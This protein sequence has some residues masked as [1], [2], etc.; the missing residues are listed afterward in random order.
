MK[1]LGKLLG[2]LIVLGIIVVGAGFF[3]LPK[4]AT[5]QEVIAVDKPAETV[6]ALLASTP[7]AGESIGEGATQTLKTA[8]PPDTVVFDV[9]YADGVKGVAT[10]KVAA[11]G[12]KASKVTVT[13]DKPLGDDINARLGALT[14][15][16][17]TP[18]M[19]SAKK[20]FLADAAKLNGEP[21]TDLVYEI[22][23][24]QPAPF[25]FTVGSAP[26]DAAQIKEAVGQGLGIVD[27]MIKRTGARID[28]APIAVETAWKDNKY[29]FTAGWK[30]LGNPP[31]IYAGGVQVGTSPGGQAIKVTYTG[32][33]D[34]VLPTYDKM[35]ALVGAARLNLGKSFEVYRDDPT[36]PGGSVDREIYYLVE[37]DASQ[38][39]K[40]LPPKASS[41]T[42]SG[43]PLLSPP[44]GAP[45]TTP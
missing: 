36:K 31:K 6:Y 24:V 8:T 5:K 16:P 21:F 18:I 42:L 34:N 10:Y 33:E 19:E 17:V 44:L 28:G 35:E 22:V 25:V 23:T 14:G 20:E 15:A 39:A 1:A 27:F 38:L 30:I 32:D 2:V 37:G 4:T 3:L 11:D 43:A 12:A 29:D 13:L 40:I 45:S 26:Q 9:A 41:D 7:T